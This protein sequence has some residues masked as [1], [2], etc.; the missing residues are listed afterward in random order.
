M[1]SG[2]KGFIIAGVALALVAVVLVVLAL[3]GGTQN[4][5]EIPAREMGSYVVAATDIPAHTILTPVDVTEVEVPVEDVPAGAAT[6]IGAVTGMAYRTPLS[7]DQV[8][9]STQLEQPGLSNDV[10]DGMRAISLPVDEDSSLYGLAANDDH[11]DIVFKA[12]VDLVRLLPGTIA[13]LPVEEAGGALTQE[14]VHAD[15]DVPAY[16]AT[17]DEGS[18]VF[19]RDGIGDEGQLEPVAKVLLQDIRILRVVRPGQSF[20]ADGEPVAETVVEEA[21]TTEDVRQGALILEVTSQQA[22]VI[23]FMQDANH[24]YQITV[25]GRDDHEVVSTSGITFEILAE[26]EDYAL[27]LPG[28]ITV[29]DP[30]PASPVGA[31]QDGRPGMTPPP[32]VTATAPAEA[33]PAA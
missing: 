18:R 28:A 19:V 14:I 23:T 17:G 16:P 9:M 27:P 15:D 30:P 3:A 26:D 12:R 25:R 8:L 24:T 1:R 21:A 11:V 31:D 6:N 5:E 33:S 29:A 2:G 7:A 32:E 4:E 10:A 22:E 20:T 13:E